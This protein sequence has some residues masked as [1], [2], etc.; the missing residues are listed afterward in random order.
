MSAD[1]LLLD[2]TFT[3]TAIDQKKYDRVARVFGEREDLKFTLDIHSELYP[4]A[5]GETI[6]LS[7]ASTLSLDGS[8][9]DSANSKTGWRET[10]SGELTLADTYDYVMYGKV[11]RFEEGNG[12]FIKVYASFGG[13]LLHIE[14]PHKRLSSLRHEYIYL[15]I[16]K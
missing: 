14:G 11:Y 10:R 7:I 5:A 8:K 15:L 16:K 3:I 9:D 2:S 13:L 1:S 4:L 12:E 6:Q